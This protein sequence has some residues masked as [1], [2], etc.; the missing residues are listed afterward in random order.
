MNSSLEGKGRGFE[1]RDEGVLIPSRRSSRI[2]RLVIGVLRLTHKGVAGLDQGALG[3]H[4]GS[5]QQR[6]TE[7]ALLV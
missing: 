6:E 2:T 7:V 3:M 4:G 1:R 5:V